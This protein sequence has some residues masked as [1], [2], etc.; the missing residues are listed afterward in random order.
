M[1]SVR[2]EPS[3][4][5]DTSWLLAAK[6]VSFV[7]S[8]ALPLFLVRHLDQVQFGLYKQAF[9]FVNSAVAIVPLG[10]GMSA[11]Y[12]LPRDPGN[13]GQTVLNIL[14]LN[15]LAG[16]LVCFALI[17]RPSIVQLIFGGPQLVSYAPALG[18]LILLWTTASSFDMIA[19]AFNDM[20]MASAIIILIQLTR[21]AF[22]LGAGVIFGSVKA[23]VWAAVIQGMC[24][25]AGFML[26]LKMR[27]PNFWRHFDVSLMRRQLSYALPLGAAGLLY[28]LQSD[29]PNYFVSRRFGPAL[30]A[31]YAIGTTQLPLVNM[32]QES[33]NSVLI[34]RISLLQRNQENREIL[35]LLTRAMRKLAAVYLPIFALLLVVG[36]ELIRIL[37]TDRYLSSWPV[38]AVNVTLLPLSIVL[39]DPLYRAYSEQRY[40]LI[41][42]RIVLVLVVILFLW[43]GTS[44]FGLVGAVGAVVA[45]N[46]AERIVM[47]IRFG[48]VMGVTRHDA[49][50]LEGVARIALAAAGAALV[51]SFIRA[52][53]L[54]ARSL[55][56][57]LVCGVVFTV[58]YAAGILLLKIPSREEKRAVL[59]WLV[60]LQNLGE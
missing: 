24:Q 50:L 25:S 39:L 18:I 3:L 14:L 54:G 10:F 51:A 41:R 17:L 8:L 20:K 60:R 19:I 55:A 56:I 36:P 30:Y 38:F 22:V 4:T 13:R 49:S 27:S 21:T 2:R 12:F 53:M 15:L 31:L 59:D 9:L 16:G 11:L 5:I 32:L 40:F 47:G 42:V 52:Q 44:H 6:T 1:A 28:T 35:H 37:F 23:L 45:V 46:L 48:R 43:F 57:L 26:Y 33:A 34:P 58:I 29:L 7:V